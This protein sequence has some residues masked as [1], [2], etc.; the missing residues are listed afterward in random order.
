[1]Y[2]LEFK[3]DAV[4][5]LLAGERM[6]ILCQVLEIGRNLL[7]YWLKRYRKQVL[8]RMGLAAQAEEQRESPLEVAT[9]R[10]TELER[11]VGQQ[12]MDVDFLR[13]AFE[14]VKESHQSNSNAGGT[15]S[16]K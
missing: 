5:R 11:K 10:I 8:E 7:Y 3:L 14:R 16:T 15:A 12:Q 9:K 6:S 1:L 2:S 4:Q 13:R